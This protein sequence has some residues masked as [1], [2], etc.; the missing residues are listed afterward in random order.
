[1]FERLKVDWCVLK[2]LL[3]LLVIVED[4]AVEMIVAVDDERKS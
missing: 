1:L 4:E 3:K 2:R